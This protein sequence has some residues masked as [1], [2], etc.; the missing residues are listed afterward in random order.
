MENA[1][2]LDIGLSTTSFDDP[3]PAG[4][5]ASVN[6]PAE[7]AKHDVARDVQRIIARLPGVTIET[8]AVREMPNGSVLLEGSLRTTSQSPSDFAGPVMD[9]TGLA[10]VIDRLRVQRSSALDETQIVGRVGD[11]HLPR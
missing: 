11:V 7:E 6:I 1:E 3:V 4:S 5:E 9:E 10:D 8:L 2:S